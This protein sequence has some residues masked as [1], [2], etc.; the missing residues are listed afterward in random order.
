MAVFAYCIL[1]AEFISRYS[2][3][4]PVR[5]AQI[6]GEATRGVMDRP[7]KRM[8]YALTGMTVFIVI[9]QDFLLLFSPLPH[10]DDLQNSLPS[11]RVH[12]RP[13]WQGLYNRMVLQ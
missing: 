5:L 8:L 11:S 7:L 10:P 1:A 3:D 4:R 6:P 2:R 13:E 9:R 12:G